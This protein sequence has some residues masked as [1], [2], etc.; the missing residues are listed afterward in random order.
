MNQQGLYMIDEDV[1]INA[2]AHKLLCE[3]EDELFLGFGKFGYTIS[4]K[5]DC[6][7][8]QYGDLEKVKLILSMNTV[9]GAVLVV[10]E[11]RIYKLY[12]WRVSQHDG[13]YLVNLA[14][15]L[16]GVKGYKEKFLVHQ[17]RQVWNAV[18]IVADWD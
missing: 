3:S 6:G 11:K 12:P 13:W 10:T 7:Q 9:N 2:K 18:Y 8:Y 1:Y 4:N 14:N 16:R 17:N 5:Q 15:T